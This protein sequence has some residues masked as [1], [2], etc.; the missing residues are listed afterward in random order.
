MGGEGESAKF[1]V[2]V[3]AVAVKC[4]DVVS[5][6]PRLCVAVCGCSKAPGCCV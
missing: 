3:V 2:S 4:V 6:A 1:T 5:G